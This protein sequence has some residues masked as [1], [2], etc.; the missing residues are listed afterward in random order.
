MKLVKN[1]L[2]DYDLKMYIKKKL[3]EVNSKLNKID[4]ALSNEMIEQISDLEK[5]KEKE[6]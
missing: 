3:L 4:Q 5:I 1:K 2:K 6:K